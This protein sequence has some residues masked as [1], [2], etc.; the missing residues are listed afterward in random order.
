MEFVD[1][2]IVAFKVSDFI[3][4][5]ERNYEFKLK[6]PKNYIRSKIKND[7]F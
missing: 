6:Y 3:E 5:I 2:E 1:I 7:I 4:K